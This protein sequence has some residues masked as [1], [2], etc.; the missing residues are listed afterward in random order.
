M[1]FNRDNWEDYLAAFRETFQTF[2]STDPDR[3]P[4][5][6]NKLVVEQVQFLFG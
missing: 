3:F 6:E 4:I 2:C 1:Y 5:G